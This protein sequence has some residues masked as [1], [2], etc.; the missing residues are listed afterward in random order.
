MLGAL[1]P[2]SR[3]TWKAVTASRSG[4]GGPYPIWT[5]DGDKVA[6]SLI[7]RSEMM[8]S[9]NNMSILIDNDK[10]ISQEKID[11]GPASGCIRH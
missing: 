4:L 6:T 9:Y 10:I 11:L 1:E 7:S 2:R 3:P 8:Q 5:P